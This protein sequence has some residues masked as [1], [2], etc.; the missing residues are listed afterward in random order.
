MITKRLMKPVIAMTLV[1][2]FLSF[3]SASFAQERR[4]DLSLQFGVMS[5]DQV[6]DVFGNIG[7]LIITLGN[8]Y[9]DNMQFSGIPVLTYHYSSNSRFGFGGALGYY[10]SWGDLVIES[11]GGVVGEYR[12]RNFTMAAELDY[13][14]IMR[15]GVQ[16]YSCAGF[17]LRVRRGRYTDAAET[18]TR[19]WA[20]P[21]VNIT[22]LGVRFGRKIGFFAEAGAGYKGMLS[23][24][25]NGQF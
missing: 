4:H 21:T 23:V 16:V 25:V 14:W 18:T 1:A 5:P 13:H 20:I 17:G 9:K 24:G 3:A 6:L 15:P 8:F 7:I 12:E 22:A 19:T 10:G 2:V 11:G